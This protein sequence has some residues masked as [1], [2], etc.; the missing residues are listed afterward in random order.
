MHYLDVKFKEGAIF[1]KR[2]ETRIDDT[3]IVTPYSRCTSEALN[4]KDIIP[5]ALIKA[6]STRVQAACKHYVKVSI[7]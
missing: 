2:S 6:S 4:Y 7:E 3:K 5:N 1:D